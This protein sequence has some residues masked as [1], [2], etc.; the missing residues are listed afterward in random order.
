[1]DLVLDGRVVGRSLAGR[2]AVARQA[3]AGGPVAVGPWMKVSAVGRSSAGGTAGGGMPGAGT[4]ARRRG[5]GPVAPGGA[6]DRA[7]VRRSGPRATPAALAHG[8]PGRLHAPG[9]A[10]WRGI[11]W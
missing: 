5:T 2:V 1:I 10:R 4:G 6:R 7:V 9:P 3:F 8:P 11:H